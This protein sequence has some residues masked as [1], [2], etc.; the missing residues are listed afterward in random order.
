MLHKG[1]M[2]THTCI[3][4]T[5][6]CSF[7]FNQWKSRQKS[8]HAYGHGS[9]LVIKDSNWCYQSSCLKCNGLFMIA[10]V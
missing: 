10:M 5:Q 8:A 7:H 1:C 6:C 9:F 2:T 3:H 4:R